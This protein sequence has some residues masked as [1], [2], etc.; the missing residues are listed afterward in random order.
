MNVQI[1]TLK[2]EIAADL[3][4]I[5][6]IYD[7]L[8]EYDTRLTGDERVIVLAYYLHNLYCAFESIFQRVASVFGNQIA[9]RSGWHAGLLRRMTLDI[10]GVRPRLLSDQSYD[11]LDELRR[12]RH[13][14]RSAYRMRLDA[15][16]L[17]LAYRRARVLER[18]Y[19]ADIEQFLAFLDGLIRVEGE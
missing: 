19:R 13:L 11:C 14:F 2:A 9:D 1:Q 16:R 7:A 4:A 5:A 15:E 8:T 3:K 12:F 17:A 6:E 10:D 18:I